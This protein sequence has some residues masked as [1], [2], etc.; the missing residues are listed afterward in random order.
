MTLYGIKGETMEN[1]QVNTREIELRLEGY[2]KGVYF[3]RL[4][5]GE[6]VVTKKL[7]VR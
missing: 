6:G 7:V 4:V 5:T 3:I 1:R 2:S